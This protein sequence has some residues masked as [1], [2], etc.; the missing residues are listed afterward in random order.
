MPLTWDTTGKRTA[1]MTYTVGKSV[2]PFAWAALVLF[3]IVD[4]SRDQVI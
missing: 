4:E 3:A 1:F 2:Q